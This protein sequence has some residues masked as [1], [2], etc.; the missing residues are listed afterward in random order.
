MLVGKYALF[1]NRK[2]LTKIYLLKLDNSF[3]VK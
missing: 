3:I 2:V 1:K